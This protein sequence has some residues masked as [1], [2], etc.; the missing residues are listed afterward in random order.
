ME[1]RY[2]YGKAHCVVFGICVWIKLHF[3]TVI[4]V[5]HILYNCNVAVLAGSWKANYQADQHARTCVSLPCQVLHPRSW[6]A[7]GRTHQVIL[8]WRTFCCDSNS[9]SS[10]VAEM[11]TQCCTSHIVERCWWV[12]S[13]NSIL[14]VI[15]AFSECKWL[16]LSVTVTRCLRTFAWESELSLVCVLHCCHNSLWMFLLCSVGICLHCRSSEI[17]WVALCSV[18]NTQLYYSPRLLCKVF[19]FTVNSLLF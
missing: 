6:V 11:A 16:W 1:L 4:L 3:V 2:I 8:C 5:Y 15:S 14:Q 13:L 18:R 17:C 10:A 19:S 12:S 7:R 9:R